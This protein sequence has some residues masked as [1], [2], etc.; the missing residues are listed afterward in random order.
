MTGYVRWMIRSD[1][2]EVERIERMA[3]P[4]DP[5]VE[6]DFLTL[7]RNRKV[8][9]MV[10]EDTDTKRLAA[11]VVYLLEDYRLCPFTLVVNPEYEKSPLADMLVRHLVREVE[12]SHRNEIILLVGEVEV[13]K[14][15]LLRRC[16]FRAVGVEKQYPP[17]GEEVVYVMSYVKKETYCYGVPE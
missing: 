15:L 4:D 3:H 10:V 6:E 13:N 8:I 7:L 2:P 9:G 1:M 17:S 14:Q 16:G 11:Y 5:R 12:K